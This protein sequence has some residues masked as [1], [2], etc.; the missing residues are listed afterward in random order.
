[1]AKDIRS[2]TNVAFFPL[3]AH[4]IFLHKMGDVIQTVDA[5]IGIATLVIKLCD[6]G[7]RYYH[8]RREGSRTQDTVQSVQNGLKQVRSTLRSRERPEH[9]TVSRRQ[10]QR[11]VT[12]VMR[13]VG[14]CK[15]SLTE[16]I[17]CVYGTTT[18]DTNAFTD[19]KLKRANLAF[20]P[21]KIG[22]LRKDLD[23]DLNALEL[24][25]ILLT[26]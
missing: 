8:T 5:C 25:L 11:Q 12:A 14:R 1:M 7:L 10:S 17:R 3:R 15:A 26:K 4:H 24:S 19:D 9:G 13:C 18:T 22:E 6:F 21:T 16:V 2:Y 20:D 23:R